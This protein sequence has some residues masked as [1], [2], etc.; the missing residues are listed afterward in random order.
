MVSAYDHQQPASQSHLHLIV[1]PSIYLSSTFGDLA[2]EREEVRRWLPEYGYL[3]KHSED[4]GIQR[5]LPR[6]LQDIDDCELYLL[7]LGP[8]Y[9]SLVRGGPL[10]EELSYTHH[11]FR[12]ARSR[13]MPCL[14]FQIRSYGYDRIEADEVARREAFWE[15]VRAYKGGFKPDVASEDLIHRITIAL[16][17]VYFNRHGLVPDGQDLPSEAVATPFE[18][19]SVPLLSLMIQVKDTGESSNG[20]RRY[21][22]IPELY[23][24]QTTALPCLHDKLWEPMDNVVLESVSEEIEADSPEQATRGSGHAISFASSVQVWLSAA[25]QCALDLPG[26]PEVILEFFLPNDLLFFDLCSLRTQSLESS[27]RRRRSRPRKMISTCCFIV[28]SLERAQDQATSR[29]ELEQKWKHV[30]D[31]TSRVVVELQGPPAGALGH[32]QVLLDW[33]DKFFDRI[34]QPRNAVCLYLPDPPAHPDARAEVIDALVQANLPLMVMWSN[35][36]TDGGE[37]L[38]QHQHRSR[39]AESLLGL[40]DSS[41]LPIEA[42]ASSLSRMVDLHGIDVQRLSASRMELYGCDDD[43]I[44]ATVLKAVMIMDVPDR[45]PS[46]TVDV[47]AA[48]ADRIQSPV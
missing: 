25:K 15:E 29:Y 36:Q 43:A 8:H 34:N 24:L 46:K 12:H 31:Q 42:E 6:C 30:S 3:C 4:A 44:Q 37:A 27:Q 35:C 5:P 47:R 19:K 32:E 21:L 22:L 33:A 26:V 38:E 48:P 13:G 28:R 7:L 41:I 1:T 2:S 20:R 9:G 18:K 39:L 10:N 11:E 16:N 17:R 40:P 23:G 45:W 14:A